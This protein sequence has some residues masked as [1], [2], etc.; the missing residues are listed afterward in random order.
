MPPPAAPA[1]LAIGRL[2][3][4]T[5]VHIETIRYY[6]KIGMLPKPGRT[7][8][9]HRSYAPEHVARLSFIRRARELGFPLEAI[10][11]LLRLNEQGACCERARDVTV[12]HRTD[13][14][15]KIADLRKLDR[16]LSALI[17][18]CQPTRWPHCPIMDALTADPAR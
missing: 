9:G 7:A 6:E 2:A 11:D 5:G 12:A 4:M 10:R 3:D 17:D 13:V 18:E 16:A 15:R 14:R 8:G 1:P